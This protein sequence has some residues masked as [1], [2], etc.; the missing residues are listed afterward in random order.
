MPKRDYDKLL[1]TLKKFN[2][3]LYL[4][5]RDMGLGDAILINSSIR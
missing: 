1:S 2:V 5:Y 4:S 3:K